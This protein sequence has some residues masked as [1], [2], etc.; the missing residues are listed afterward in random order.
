MTIQRL[1]YLGI[2]PINHHP[3]RTLL[4]MPTRFC[5]QELDI[6]LSCEA[7]LVPGKYRSGCSVIHWT[8]HRVTNEGARESTQGAEGVCIP[9][10][11]TIW[12]NQYPQSSLGLNHQSKKTCGGTYVSSCICSRGWPS[13]PLVGGEAL[14]L[15]EDSMPQYR[16]RPGPGSRS[17]WVGDQ[18]DGGGDS[19]FSE[20][21]IG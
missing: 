7:L 1:H 11:R 2:H 18:G 14:G 15:C 17:G 16:G 20:R 3:T 13:W 5:W 10:A 4:Q 9:M 19:I 8:E 21:K 6:A 12:T